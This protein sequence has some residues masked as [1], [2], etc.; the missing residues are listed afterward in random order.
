MTTFP[1][2]YQNRK[3][4]RS[5]SDLHT[6]EFKMEKKAQWA[7]FYRELWK[8]RTNWKSPEEKMAELNLKFKSLYDGA[9]MEALKA[10]LED[11][12]SALRQFMGK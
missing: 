1:P 7:H 12:G 11:C 6:R 5:N 3:A 10:G 8:K 2:G 4:I 9:P